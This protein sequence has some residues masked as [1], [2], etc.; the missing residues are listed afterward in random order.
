MKAAG[1]G[2]SS[3]ATVDGAD[4]IPADRLFVLET[5][6]RVN[7]L[8]SD[9]S[10]DETLEQ[11]GYEVAA[12]RY[13]QGRM[14]PHREDIDWQQLGES[15]MLQVIERGRDLGPVVHSATR[16]ARDRAGA[17]SASAASQAVPGPGA[18]PYRG[19][20]DPQRARPVSGHT[21]RRHGFA[22]R[23]TPPAITKLVCALVDRK[24]VV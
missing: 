7:H 10:F 9:L 11:V 20:C 8:A 21:V 15:F 24:S 3:G 6:D 22:E 2:W 4:A 14:P 5:L 18:D 19:R 1:K 13:G 17:G 12:T 16:R 23:L